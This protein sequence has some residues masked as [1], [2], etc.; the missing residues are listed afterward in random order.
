MRR[1][2]MVDCRL[3]HRGRIGMALRKIADRDQRRACQITYSYL[4]TAPDSE[5]IGIFTL[6]ADDVARDCNLSVEEATQALAKLGEIGLVQYDADAPLVFVTDMAEM[7]YG[8]ELVV[9]G[10]DG[11]PDKR[12]AHLV[13][14]L[15]SLG[16]HP[17]VQAFLDKY[18]EAYHL[19]G[20]GIGGAS[21][22]LPRG[23]QAPPGDPHPHPHPDGDGK[24]ESERGNRIGNGSGILATTDA[25]LSAYKAEASLRTTV[26]A[27]CVDL[28]EGP[29]GHDGAVR[30]IAAADKLA[31]RKPSDRDF[32]SKVIAYFESALYGQLSLWEFEQKWD[33]FT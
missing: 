21:K 29:L 28:R 17:F 15:R 12:H 3:V 9:A 24:G 6:L 26:M 7:V 27:R 2:G 16:D 10:K 18:G 5:Q 1:F 22:G 13:G 4:L 31:R 25:V 30:L 20:R 14:T 33:R 23:T 32:R 11:K 8:P 19:N